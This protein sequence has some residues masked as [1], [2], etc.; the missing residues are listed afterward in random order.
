MIPYTSGF[1]GQ[2]L[3]DKQK[4]SLQVQVC[5]A[6]N[7]MQEQKHECHINQSTR[8]KPWMHIATPMWV[9]GCMQG[10]L[11]VQAS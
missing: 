7:E 5:A 4:L 10:Q 11:Q 8:Y 6:G 1:L 2:L 3:T 9:L